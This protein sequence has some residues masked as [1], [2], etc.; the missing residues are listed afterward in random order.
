M[1]LG[2]KKSSFWFYSILFL[3]LAYPVN[4]RLLRFFSPPDVVFVFVLAVIFFWGG[5]KKSKVDPLVFLFLIFVLVTSFFGSLFFDF[6]VNYIAFFYKYLLMFLLAWFILSA[7]LKKEQIE[8]LLKALLFSFYFLVL[9]VYFYQYRVFSGARIFPRPD[10]PFSSTAGL[11][12]GGHLYGAYLSTGVMACSSYWIFISKKSFF[13]IP[14]LFLTFGAILLTGSRAPMIAMLFGYVILLFVCSFGKN[15]A[16]SLKKMFLLMLIIS[17]IAFIILTVFAGRFAIYE[18]T[19][20]VIDRSV[21]FSD[22]ASGSDGSVM[23]RM[24]KIEL[25]TGTVLDH[26]VMFGTGVSSTPFLWVD[27]SVVRLLIDS[28]FGGLVLFAII[29]VLFIVN[30]FKT[31]K[32]N[33]NMRLFYVFFLA[34]FTYF[35]NSVSTEFFLV[36][37]SVFPF[38]ILICLLY[39]LI[40]VKR[41]S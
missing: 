25:G 2:V 24:E 15:M 39:K 10:F 5:L 31:A 34:C 32:T 7:D 40:S 16:A 23:G 19:M 33:G 38:I 9:Y 3:I 20:D 22:I 12:S 28:G 8:L 6:S 30:A 17:S 29:L 4:I 41:E 35:V 37:R 11:S 14:L 18:K 1:W 21:S 36:A 13:W 27:N 26:S